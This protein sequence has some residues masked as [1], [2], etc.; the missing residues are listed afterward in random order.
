MTDQSSDPTISVLAIE[1]AIGEYNA[2][3][4]HE[5][6][7]C[8]RASLN[9]GRISALRAD[10][11]ALR[12]IMDEVVAEIEDHSHEHEDEHDDHE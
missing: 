4:V 10:I 9:T 1:H 8:S 2:M 12:E 11:I 3:L 7:T 6:T 5:I